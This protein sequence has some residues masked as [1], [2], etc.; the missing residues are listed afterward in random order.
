MILITGGA[1]QLA[2][3]FSRFFKENS[4]EFTAPKRAELDIRDF[5]KV[6][7]FVK[8][9]GVTLIINCAAYNF[10]D[11][12]EEEPEIANAV[13]AFAV[14][15]LAKVAKELEIEFVTYSTDFVFDGKKLAPYNEED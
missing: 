15:N 5:E 12:A 10:V 14:E 2:Q 9:N 6:R 4:I 13:N 11:K 1:G 3:E 7:E 8:S